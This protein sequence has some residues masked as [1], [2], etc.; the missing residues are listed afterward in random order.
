MTDVTN[1]IEMNPGDVAADGSV[2]VGIS[3]ST[4]Q[5]LYASAAD[6]EG[7]MTWRKAK[8]AAKHSEVHGHNDWRLPTPA[9]LTVMIDNRK[10]GALKDTFNSYG[11]AQ[12]AFYWSG[13][14]HG[15]RYAKAQC[16][17]RGIFNGS[18]SIRKRG[19]LSVRLVRC[20]GPKAI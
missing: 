1:D 13:S 8:K 14:S 7:F 2:F 4:K 16:S 10:E 11:S 18:V 5:P 12:K 9:E 20:E 15:L 17:Y 3:P 6:E 19:H